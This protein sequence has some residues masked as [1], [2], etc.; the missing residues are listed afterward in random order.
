M[1]ESS[2]SVFLGYGSQDAGAAPRICEALRAA[3]VEVWFDQS[4]L[5]SGDAWD[6]Q[7]RKQIH[8]CARFIPIISSH[9]QARLVRIFPS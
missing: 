5:R 4:E 8:A 1:T 6:R 9:A 2:K 3:G 7:I